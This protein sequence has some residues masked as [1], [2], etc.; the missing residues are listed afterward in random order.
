MKSGAAGFEPL[1]P[2][3]AA[4][5]RPLPTKQAVTQAGPCPAREVSDGRH[6]GAHQGHLPAC[7][8]RAIHT[9]LGRFLAGCLGHSR[10]ADLRR[11]SIGG[12]STNSKDGVGGSIPPGLHTI[13]T[14]QAGS[15]PRLRPYCT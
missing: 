11:S 4:G 1:T 13:P 6:A 10:H 8:P 15:T 14:A 9:G 7:H 2:T 12:D 3:A 5:L